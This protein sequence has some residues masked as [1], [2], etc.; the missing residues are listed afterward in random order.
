M[1][2]PRPRLAFALLRLLAGSAASAALEGDLNERYA[3]TLQ[4]G[5][6]AAATM[7]LRREIL[8]SIAP[9]ARERC[10]SMYAAHDALRI[11]VAAVFG[12]VVVV[13]G[14][15]AAAAFSLRPAAMPPFSLVAS[16]A[17]YSPLGFAGAVLVFVVAGAAVALAC[18]RGAFR[19][20]ALVALIT[21]VVGAAVASTPSGSVFAEFGWRFALPLPCLL[22]GCL[23]VTSARTVARR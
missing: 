17:M 20:A 4:R 18:G 22:A 14:A 11:A 16:A 1:S 7:W 5:G 6:K 9:L 10:R 13:L 8:R 2:G 15:V 23:A 21:A 19:S 3:H 12:Y